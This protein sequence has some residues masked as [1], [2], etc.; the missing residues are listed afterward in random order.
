MRRAGSAGADD[1]R[2]LEV[3]KSRL[4]LTKSVPVDRGLNLNK[5][6]QREVRCRV[7]I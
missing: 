1:Q 2:G 4:Q 7:T 6:L 3:V 5:F